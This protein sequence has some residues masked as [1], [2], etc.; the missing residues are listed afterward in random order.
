MQSSQK[1]RLA[2][3]DIDGTIFRSSL[4]IELFNELVRRGVF[5]KKASAEVERDYVAWL[6]RK[7][8]Y[9]DYLIKLVSVHYRY[10]TGCRVSQVEPAIR[11]VVAWQKDRVYRYT[12][13]LVRSLKKKGYYLLA[14]SN[15][16][17]SLVGKFAHEMGFHAAIGRELEVIKGK[18]TDRNM[19][20]GQPVP[21][22]GHIDKVAILKTFLTRH[23]LSADPAQ[24]IMVGDSE[25]D[26]PLLSYVGHP[27]TFNPSGPLAHIARRRGW[28]IVVERKD[29]V[30]DIKDTALIPVSEKQ[31]VR[32]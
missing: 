15:S 13:D 19:I 18:Y 10:Q 24:S 26:L 28:K 29:V 7:G 9:N 27:I 3:F 12:R 1:V 8:H 6:N 11:A 14:I 22:M 17:Q 32:L 25:G 20:D 16:P 23:H 21:T 4:L 31:R 5:P 30:Y 2:I